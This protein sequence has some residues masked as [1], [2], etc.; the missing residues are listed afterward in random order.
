MSSAF[1]SAAVVAPLMLAAAGAFV[2]VF[3]GWQDRRDAK[4]DRPQ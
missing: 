4:R 3:T 1:M 2:F